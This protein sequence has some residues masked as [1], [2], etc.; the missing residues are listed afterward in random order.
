MND[1]GEII[2][3]QTEDGLAKIT[4]SMRDETVW[5]SFQPDDSTA[6][7]LRPPGLMLPYLCP[8]VSLPDILLIRF[9]IIRHKTFYFHVKIEF[10]PKICYRL[11]HR[12]GMMRINGS[13]I[14]P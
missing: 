14:Y 7:P 13:L 9:N 11:H 6:C 4:V 12:R 10:F 3:Y 1:R 8:S 5:L 2:F